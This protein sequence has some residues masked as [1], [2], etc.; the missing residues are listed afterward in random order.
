VS[1]WLPALRRAARGEDAPATKLVGGARLGGALL[2]G[3]VVVGARPA[4][5]RLQGRFR[6]ADAARSRRGRQHR[7]RHSV[8]LEGARRRS[9]AC[10][11]PP[12]AQGNGPKLELT[13][14]FWNGHL[15][16]GG[17]RETRVDTAVCSTCLSAVGCNPPRKSQLSTWA[18]PPS[19]TPPLPPFATRDGGGYQLGDRGGGIRHA[20]RLQDLRQVARRNGRV[21]IS[22]AEVVCPA[23]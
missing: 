4:E 17:K 6:A 22:R 18:R 14:K 10:T 11:G 5:R 21:W 13:F 2:L 7:R 16:T 23:L 3:G 15:G 20:A 12:R 9:C 1:R 19:F 8:A